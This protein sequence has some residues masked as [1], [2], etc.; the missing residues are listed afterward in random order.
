LGAWHCGF[1]HAL[2]PSLA[3]T[4]AHHDAKPWWNG[5]A[6]ELV[7]CER[8][9]ADIQ[10]SQEHL[11]TS[12][13]NTTQPQPAPG[14]PKIGPIQQSPPHRWL[15]ATILGIGLT[16]L[17]SDW[18]HEIATAVLPA[19]LVSLGAGP[20][21]L[22]AIEGVSDGLSSITKLVS[23]YWTDRLRSRK[24]F[25]VSAYALTALATGAI[26]FA[27]SGLQVMFAR[28]TAWLARGVRNPAKKALLASA[29]PAEAYGRAFGLERMMDTL[30]AIA[31][32][33]TALWL[34]RVTSHNYH[35]ILLWTLLPGLGAAA[36]FG[37][38]V[39]ERQEGPRPQK[40]FVA[41]L[42]G[43]PGN[44]RWLL[45][46]SAVFGLGDFSHTMLIL[47]ATQKLTPSLGK[48][49]AASAAIG[50]YLFHNVFYAGFAYVGG[51]LSDRA[52]HR[53]IVLAC[54]FAIAAAMAALLATGGAQRSIL[55]AVFALGGT[56]TGVVEALED[57]LTAFLVPKSQHGMAYGSLAAVNAI[58]DFASSA[59]I[60]ALWTTV[61]PSI[62]FTVAGVLFVTAAFLVL[63]LREVRAPQ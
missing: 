20:A 28:S 21:W 13:P 39:R 15:N 16:S 44:F 57:S 61:S 47:Y 5:K 1:S 22:G 46:A 30:G 23:G 60:G 33:L 43:L 10:N 9:D 4:L 34:L 41:G 38:L 51:W 40:K 11:K 26:G 14:L 29:V 53:K 8:W 19:L 45:F 25:V 2:I 56:F 12:E 59:V 32:P 37:A 7:H 50:L 18:S 31:A 6:I 36:S 35:E 62:A 52:S 63:R 58:G 27:S 42:K 3:R 24:P 49:L 55:F 48:T 17:L 54:G